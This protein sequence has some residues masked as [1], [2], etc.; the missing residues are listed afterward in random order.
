[1]GS[2]MT[3]NTGFDDAKQ[4]AWLL[5]PDV[6]YCDPNPGFSHLV[7]EVN[8]TLE[9]GYKY[10]ILRSGR[11]LFFWRYDAPLLEERIHG[12]HT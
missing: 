10:V 8:P 12:G 6:E 5:L 11:L 2:L 4:S 3:S 9:N 7:I 1:M